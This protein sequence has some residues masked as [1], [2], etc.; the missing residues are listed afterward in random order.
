MKN[1]WIIKDKNA[2]KPKYNQLYKSGDD[3]HSKH[4]VPLVL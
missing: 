2:I 1:Q 3:E 4:T